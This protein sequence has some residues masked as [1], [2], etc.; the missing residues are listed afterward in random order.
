MPYGKKREAKRPK[1]RHRHRTEEPLPVG[2]KVSLELS[3]FKEGVKLIKAY[4]SIL[5][6]IGKEPV[7]TEGEPGMAVEFT[8]I[9]PESS[10]LKDKIAEKS[11]DG[12]P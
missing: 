3:L 9:D 8:Y 6:V 2:S 7:H 5:S 11:S 1:D 10:A 12:K 4:G